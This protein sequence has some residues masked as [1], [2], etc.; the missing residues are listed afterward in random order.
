MALVAILLCAN[1]VS[2]SKDD[3]GNSGSGN[4]NSGNSGSSTPDV[5]DVPIVNGSY[6]QGYL[7]G[8]S[9][10]QYGIFSLISD[11]YFNITHKGDSFVTE[12]FHFSPTYIYSIA[13]SGNNL[14]ML[15]L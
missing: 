12:T 7:A 6:Q 4:G 14:Q 1:F 10:A 11:C 3:S 9:Q 15:G 5:P 2:C 8:L 13:C